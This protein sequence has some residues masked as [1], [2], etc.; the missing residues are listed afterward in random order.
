MPTVLL[1]RHGET[2][3]NRSGVLAGRLPGV[4]LTPRG[5]EQARA[6]GLRIQDLPLTHIV[7]SPL[8]R[9]R[10]TAK[11]MKGAAGSRIS[12]RAHVGLIECDYGAWSGK[13][14]SALAKNPLWTTVQNRPS[15]VTFPDGESMRDM[16]QR[17]V[18][19]V[20]SEHSRAE[21]LGGPNAV[22]VAVTH[23]D[24]IKA[25][26][27]D[28]LGLHLDNFQ[29]INA[30]P[31]S[32]TIITHGKAGSFVIATNTRAGELAHLASSASRRA[33]GQVGGG[34]G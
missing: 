25:I 32:I 3:A 2:H 15:H 30:D 14:L 10:D 12:I 1:V 5:Q 23:G 7:T 26:V 34:R 19:A 20:L 22:W 28:A 29:R 6:A 17:A 8:E 4:T 13:K 21:S 9:T 33:Q 24:V 11:L 27:A 31:G 18:A 16:A